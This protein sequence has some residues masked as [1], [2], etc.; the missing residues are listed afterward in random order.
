MTGMFGNDRQER[1]RISALEV[2]LEKAEGEASDWEGQVYDLRWRLRKVEKSVMVM[3][4]RCAERRQAQNA[5]EARAAASETDLNDIKEEN[6]KIQA[7]NEGLHAR[8]T[9]AERALVETQDRLSKAVKRGKLASDVLSAA[10]DLVDDGL[11]QDYYYV[12]LRAAVAKYR[13]GKKS[14]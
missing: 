7:D 1:G 9:A 6:A 14:E 4:E 11:E 2:Q 13:E 5:A 12:K 10:V 8:L 3:A